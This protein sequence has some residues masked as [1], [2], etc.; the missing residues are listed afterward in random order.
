[1]NVVLSKRIYR[2][3]LF[4][5]DPESGK[6][7]RGGVRVKLQDQPFRV[8][9]LLLERAGEVVPREQLRQALWPAD[10][11]VEF[12]GSLNAAL[13]RLRYALGDPAENPVFIET[14]PKRGYRFVAPVTVK[15]T[16]AP[17]SPAEISILKSAESG[18]QSPISSD[19][20]P[21]I[22]WRRTLA[23]T[24][25]VLV[26]AFL[27]VASYHRLT[28]GR[29]RELGAV[30]RPRAVNP[31]RS[32]AVLGFTNTSGRAE[33]AWLTT[34]LSEM[35]STELSAGDQLRLVSAEDVAQL[36]M[37]TPWTQ[38]GTLNQ[39]TTSRIGTTLGGDLLVL[40]SYASVGPSQ[41]RQVRLDVRLQDAPSGN[42]LLQVSAT[43]REND[44]FHLA[45]DVGSR[46]RQK[47]GVAGETPSEQAA[48]VASIPSNPEATR[49]YSLGLEKLRQYDALPARD[50]FQQAIK[51][52]PQYALA[53][54]ALSETWSRL[55]YDQKAVDEARK[56]YE[57]AANLP[58]RDR[59]FVEA[60]YRALNK[61]W[62][63]A[64]QAYRT[65]FD[66]FPDDLDYGLHLADVQTRA[67]KMSDAEA[68]IQALRKLPSPSGQDPRIDLAE[69][70]NQHYPGQWEPAKNA[71][72]Q[73]VA[74]ARTRSLSFLL[75]EALDAE[76]LDL[77]NL[78]EHD[79]AIAAAEEAK[80]VYSNVGDQFGVATALADIGRV[81]YYRGEYEASEK[82]A[83]QALAIDRTIGSKR[84]M[85]LELR[86]LGNAR[87]MRGDLS[88]AKDLYQE[89]LD[90]YREIGDRGL[91][92]YTLVPIAWGLQATGNDAAALPIYDQALAIF[93]DMSN[94]QGIASVLEERVGVLLVMGELSKADADCRQA[95]D[96]FRKIG[97]KYM[98]AR[99]LIYLGSIAASQDR[100]E[101]SRRAY[102]DALA[103]T[104]QV[105]DQGTAVNA[106]L[107]L[108][109]VAEEQGHP[110]EARQLLNS[111]LDYLHQHQD[112]NQEM[113]AE[114]K[115]ATVALREGN[116]AEAEAAMESA[117][118]SFKASHWAEE[119]YIFKI[120]D[121]RLQAATGKLPGARRLLETVAADAAKHNHVYYE[122]E[123]R[124]AQCE[125]EARTEPAAAR[126]HAKILEKEA[127]AKGFT[128]IARKAADLV[129]GTTRITAAR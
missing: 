72:I 5:A 115:L 85:G 15:Q 29:D 46:L 105:G 10:T 7:L 64:L 6:L 16:P 108:A 77:A 13:K 42:I 110:A 47:L 126:V 107:G 112:P 102:S 103:S 43:G 87:A 86:F 62:D 1:M 89:A 39:E 60:R 83:E 32:V 127:T 2:F 48:E 99:T 50:L 36:R 53:H 23:V 97:E 90:I 27:M 57:L 3:G 124:L 119:G 96:M 100:L 26:L 4:E 22:H 129:A 73:A 31:R 120:A 20:K 9:C 75:A 19:L 38:T 54:A 71:A 49:L 78:G 122:L 35:L 30:S 125:V 33:D 51:T 37:V 88:G 52:D 101:D 70:W 59:L 114:S 84:G 81:Q 14:L 116:L 95:L 128:L 104:R 24:A 113:S 80:S 21:P 91:T 69:E 109:S 61:E 117:R 92:A 58:R 94:Q 98:I 68:T 8:L 76:A 40:G 28:S 67:G 63:K 123:A 66:F 118:K 74:K 17:D 82:T 11:Y 93:R 34:A 44:L 25:V 106:E 56:A 18:S 65:L 55:G 79:K 41:N 45:A 12:D 121:A 111:A